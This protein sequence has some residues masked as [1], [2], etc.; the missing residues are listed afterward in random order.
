MRGFGVKF[1][2]S[3]STQNLIFQNPCVVHPQRKFWSILKCSM[4]KD[5]PVFQRCHAQVPVEDFYKRYNRVILLL[6]LLD[7]TRMLDLIF[8][9]SKIVFIFCKFIY[10]DAFLTPALAI[11]EVIANVCVLHLLLTL[12]NVVPKE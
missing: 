6:L 12:K 5:S 1:L 4:L 7:S 9:K 11:K 8:L 3:I 2:L 10:L